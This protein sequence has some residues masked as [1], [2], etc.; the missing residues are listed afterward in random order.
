MK[1]RH[2]L[3]PEEKRAIQALKELALDWPESLWLFS[4][5]GDLWVMRKKGKE[6]AINRN[7]GMDQDYIVGVI[8][9]ENDGGDW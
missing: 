9:I 5:S 2:R 3:T 1:K 8:D 4:A 6:K 7:G